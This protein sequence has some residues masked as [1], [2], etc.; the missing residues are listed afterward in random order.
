MAI[1]D[2]GIT[3]AMLGDPAGNTIELL[4]QL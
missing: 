3:I 2:L 1:N 4:Q